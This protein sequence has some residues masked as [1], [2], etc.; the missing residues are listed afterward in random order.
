MAAVVAAGA[1]TVGIAAH[2][3]TQTTTAAHPDGHLV[4]LNMADSVRNQATEGDYW[5][6]ETQDQ[7]L[8]VVPATDRQQAF[9]LADSSET[10]WSL[11]V[12]PG[13]HG[14]RV[15]DINVRRGPLT[16]E[17]KRRWLLAGAPDTVDVD[18]GVTKGGAKLVVPIGAGS[19][20]VDHTDYGDDIVALG[21]KNVNYAY[22]RALPADKATLAAVLNKLYQ[23][24]GGAANTDQQDWMFTQVSNL[25]TFPVSD[26]VR[27]AAYRVLASLPGISSLGNVTDP[28]GRAG[29]G[30]AL[31]GQRYGDL[32]EE[33]QQLIVDPATSTIL[34]QQTML[35]APSPYAAGA[36]LKAGTVIYYQAT[37][38]IGWTDRQAEIPTT[39]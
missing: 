19:P 16:A 7:Y 5:Q 11:P 29:V 8:S 9:V 14:L 33:Q 12:K 31:P 23:Q 17:D 26:E 4:L 15:S 2:R 35:L 27:A 34:S 1:V 38:H 6:F 30:V 21:P 3:G 20:R 37:T 24:D 28:L 32:G 18:P 13:E 22:L 10:D 36:G 25:I 39:R